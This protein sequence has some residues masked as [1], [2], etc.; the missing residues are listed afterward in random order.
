MS[1]LSRK[2][3]RLRGG[4]SHEITETVKLRSPI[5]WDRFDQAC[6]AMNLDPDAVRTK[7]REAW[8]GAEWPS[9]DQMQEFVDLIVDTPG[10]Y[11]LRR[12][13]E[14]AAAKAF[15]ASLMGFFLI[16]SQ[17]NSNGLDGS[18]SGSSK[19]PAFQFQMERAFG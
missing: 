14:T 4:R 16:E 5:T 8:K 6:Y 18:Q 11:D 13:F 9:L 10:K 3:R 7:G 15:V 2:T 1:W 17:M 19:P 12:D